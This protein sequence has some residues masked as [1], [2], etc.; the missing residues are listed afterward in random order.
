V[1][2]SPPTS[3][4]TCRDPALNGAAARTC[5]V[6]DEI[7]IAASSY[8]EPHDLYTLE[9]RVLT[10]Q[11][12]N[13]VGQRPSYQVFETKARKFNFRIL[14]QGADAGAGHVQN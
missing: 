9:P 5:Q 1:H 12:D 10:F 8:V 6:G 11:P 7:I 3:S 2:G 14:E 13:R 4:T